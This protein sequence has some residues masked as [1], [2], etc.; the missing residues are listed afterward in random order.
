MLVLNLSYSKCAKKKK[1]NKEA[2]YLLFS[3]SGLTNKT[4]GFS[5]MNSDI[6]LDASLYSNGFPLW[7][8]QHTV[9]IMYTILKWILY[10]I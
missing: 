10:H 2:Q 6:V 9:I 3:A 4:Q 5:F 7:Q 8:G 1:S